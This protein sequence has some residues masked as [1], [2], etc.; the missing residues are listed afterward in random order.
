MPWTD[1]LKIGDH[2][3]IKHDTSIAYKIPPA[4]F[5]P[6]SVLK[7]LQDKDIMKKKQ[8]VS[9]EIPDKI[10]KGYL[11]SKYK[12]SDIENFLCRQGIIPAIIGGL[13]TPNDCNDTIAIIAIATTEQHFMPCTL[14]SFLLTPAV[15]EHRF[16]AKTRWTLMPKFTG[17]SEGT[18]RKILPAKTRLYLHKHV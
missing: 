2:P 14:I 12:K 13:P 17:Y 15:P 3:F 16:W 10:R 8:S 1:T 18:F 4:L 9:P 7:E 5:E 6:L 11:V